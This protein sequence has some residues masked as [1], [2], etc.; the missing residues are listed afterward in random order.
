MS[1]GVRI[2]NLLDFLYVK[3]YHD[4]SNYSSNSS[5]FSLYIGYIYIYN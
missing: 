3:K 2:A 5:A 1:Y 4:V